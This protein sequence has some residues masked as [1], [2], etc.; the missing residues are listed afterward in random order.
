[1]LERDVLAGT[2]TT[3]SRC[4]TGACVAA[5]FATQGAVLVR[6]T[7][8]VD[9]PILRFSVAGWETFVAGLKH[10]DFNVA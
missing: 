6:D 10:D 1:M 4:A 5:S 9:G 3:S 7:K 8:A 2:W